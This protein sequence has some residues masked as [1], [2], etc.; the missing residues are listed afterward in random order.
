MSTNRNPCP[1]CGNQMEEGFILEQSVGSYVPSI[2]VQGP[3]EPSFW[4]STQVKGKTMR[5]VVTY[6]CEGC[7]FLESYANAEWKGRIKPE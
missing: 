3:P 6:R 5:L 2:W 4:T 7:G 1:K